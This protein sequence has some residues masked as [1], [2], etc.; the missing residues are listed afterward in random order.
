MNAYSKLIQQTKPM[1]VL[2]LQQAAAV[3]FLC[4]E[5]FHFSAFLLVPEQNPQ[6]F[7]LN[8]SSELNIA[9]IFLAL[10]VH[11]LKRKVIEKQPWSI[12]KSHRAVSPLP[13][14]NQ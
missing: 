10:R 12:R 14:C 13:L 5:Q 11:T 7:F 9:Q 4:E 1:I 2:H 6:P 3:D 8:P